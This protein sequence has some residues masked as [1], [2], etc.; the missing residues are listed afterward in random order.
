MH[1]ADYVSSVVR[2]AAPLSAAAGYGRGTQALSA[3]LSV[4]VVTEVH[5]NDHTGYRKVHS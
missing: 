5:T 3:H 1:E 2:T 4:M